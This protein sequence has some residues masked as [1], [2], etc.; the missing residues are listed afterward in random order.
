MLR[1]KA[2]RRRT[3]SERMREAFRKIEDY[4]QTHTQQELARKLEV[5]KTTVSRWLG[6]GKIHQAYV[7]FIKEKL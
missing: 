6:S 3:G 2:T 5:S 1:F 7:K 4:L